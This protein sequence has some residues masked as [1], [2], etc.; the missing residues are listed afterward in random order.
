[1]KLTIGHVYH[2]LEFVKDPLE[3][4][5]PIKYDQRMGE[6]ELKVMSTFVVH[7]R[8]WFLC[9]LCAE[10]GQRV[11]SR[12]PQRALG[13]IRYTALIRAVDASQKE[14]WDEQ[15]SQYALHGKEAATE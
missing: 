4:I 12:C 7:H 10:V 8:L 3:K 14:L 13:R 9:R 6:T 11:L 1:M 15:E 2:A 5:A